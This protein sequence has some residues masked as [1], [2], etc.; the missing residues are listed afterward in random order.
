[1]KI[2]SYRKWIIAFLPFR[3]CIS[4][5]YRKDIYKFTHIIIGVL[6]YILTSLYHTIDYT[7]NTQFINNPTW[8]CVSTLYN[9]LSASYDNISFFL[10]SISALQAPT[11][12]L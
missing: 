7:S 2:L 4:I 3:K 10:D 9:V 8:Y 1:M 12:R 5:N 11:L 6:R